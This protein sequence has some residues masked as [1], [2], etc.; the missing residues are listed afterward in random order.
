M[1]RRY[2][3]NLFY[4]MLINS[5][6]E[7]ESE[8]DFAYYF[9]QALKKGK[10]TSS[11][12]Q[13]VESR[14]FD[15][16]WI[17]EIE[18][19]FPSIDKIAR[20]LK[21]VLR[22]DEEVKIIEKAKKTDSNSIRHL[23]AN[24]HLIKEVKPNVIPKKVL[25][26]NPEIDYSI[27]ENRFIMTLI[28]RL[29]KYVKDRLVIIKKHVLPIETTNLNVKSEFVFEKEVFDIDLTL[30]KKD[31]LDSKK[32]SSKN[33]DLL[34]RVEYL[35]KQIVRLQKSQF[36]MFLKGSKPVIPPIMK[37]QIILKNPDYRNAYSLWLYL[38]KTIE[39]DFE[40]STTK[41]QKR[42][43]KSYRK[44][45]TQNILFLMTTAMFHE[46]ARN[47]QSGYTK[48][49][50]RKYQSV[51]K[52]VN[53]IEFLPN[54]LESFQL[55][56]T[57]INEY[58]LM[59]TKK[60]LSKQIQNYQE[61]GTSYRVSMKKAIFDIVNLSNALYYSYFGINPED[62]FQIEQI[63]K[64][65]SSKTDLAD[66]LEK[67]QVTRMLRE[68]KERDLKETMALEIKWQNIVE[69]KQNQYYHDLEAKQI[70]KTQQQIAKEIENFNKIK[71]REIN[72]T[73]KNKEKQLKDHKEK[74]K[75]YDLKKKDLHQKQLQKIKE[76]EAKRL[77]KVQDKNKLKKEKLITNEKKKRLE[78]K[79]S[80][81]EKNKLEKT[82]IDN[83][84]QLKD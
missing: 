2:D 12:F 10:T 45:L 83:K 30:N 25:V 69:N 14:V 78:L 55:D 3:L 59:Q 57:A 27:Y 28:N 52:K 53:D 15:D 13:L 36:M 21:S 37:T 76:R 51:L 11:Q 5:F 74:L 7:S 1:K 56:T 48:G 50:K 68:A 67:Y 73:R 23:A 34:K 20:N 75:K 22:Q 44:H 71:D 24:T 40:L 62:E 66:A 77:A 31:T 8:T 4:D 43:T 65:D 6:D 35:Y 26:I 33:I 60:L 16:A 54:E 42:F 19:Y 38:D 81:Q 82:K 47:T 80:L 41:K 58:Y 79:E 32:D 18:A 46:T 61:E 49:I 17:K 64:P 29:E 72:I 70:D 63:T 39:L 84:Y 9:Y